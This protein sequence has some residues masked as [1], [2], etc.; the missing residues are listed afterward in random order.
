MNRPYL[1]HSML[2]PARGRTAVRPL[3]L[4]LT[5]QDDVSPTIRVVQY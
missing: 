1:R 2:Q 5:S 4:R 3:L